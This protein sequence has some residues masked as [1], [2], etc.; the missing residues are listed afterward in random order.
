MIKLICVGKLKDQHLKALVAEYN[1]RIKKYHR[2]EIVEIPWRNNLLQEKKAIMRQIDERALVIV[3]S[4][5]GEQYDSVAFSQLIAKNLQ[6]YGK[7]NFII[8][9]AEGLDQEFSKEKHIAFSPMTFP[10]QLFRLIFLEQLYRAFTILNNEN[11]H[12]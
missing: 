10:H 2:L 9:G 1:K 3:L 8:G 6:Q 5:T 11:Y 4:A 7:I 12:K